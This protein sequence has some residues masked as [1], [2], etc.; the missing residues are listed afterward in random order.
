[1]KIHL[2]LPIVIWIAMASVAMAQEPSTGSTASSPF[3]TPA[4][5]KAIHDCAA[6]QGVDFPSQPSPPPKLTDAQAKIVKA[7]FS[8]NG[9]TPPALPSLPTLPALPSLPQ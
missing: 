4:Q 7:C 1:M 8:A 3:P 9:V 2:S 6:E 5:L